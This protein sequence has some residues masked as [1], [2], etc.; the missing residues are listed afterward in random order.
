MGEGGVSEDVRRGACVGGHLCA[1]IP[2]REL[3]P[4]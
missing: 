3:S 1:N 4:L 2:V